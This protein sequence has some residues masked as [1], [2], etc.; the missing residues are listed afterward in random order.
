MADINTVLAIALNS[1]LGV[2]ALLTAS[3]L[4]NSRKTFALILSRES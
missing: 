2:E 1:I 4:D 3:Y